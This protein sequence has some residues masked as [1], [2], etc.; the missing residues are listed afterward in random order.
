MDREDP[1][2]MEDPILLSGPIILAKIGAKQ[3]S[4][5]GRGIIEVLD[6][7]KIFEDAG[8]LCCCIVGAHPLLYYGAKVVPMVSTAINLTKTRTLKLNRIGISAYQTIASIQ[9]RTCS[10]QNH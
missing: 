5:S 3:A 4:H 8:I 6:V 10:S 7:I 9:Q 1:M 2:D